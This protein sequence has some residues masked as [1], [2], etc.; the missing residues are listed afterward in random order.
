VAKKLYVGNIPYDLT[1][2]DLQDMFKDHGSVLSANIITDKY[3]GRSKGFGFVEM[4]N[5]DEAVTAIESLNE[6][7]INGRKILV[8]EARPR[9]D[10]PRRP[11]GGRPGGDRNDRNGGRRNGNGYGNRR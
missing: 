10:K 8:N 6:K 1:N 4:E 3:S 2:E 9:E 11:G 7:E 5:D